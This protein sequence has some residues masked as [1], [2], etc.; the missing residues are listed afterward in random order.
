MIK[1]LVNWLKGLTYYRCQGYW[2]ES[3]TDH[4][5]E[6]DCNAENSGEFTC[7]HCLVNGGIYN[8]DTGKED[9]IRYFLINYKDIL[10]GLFPKI[11]FII[12]GKKDCWNC[13]HT[14]YIDLDENN[15]TLKCRRV[16]GLIKLVKH[17]GYCIHWRNKN[18]KN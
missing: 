2:S 8:P 18:D 6:F 10:K 13:K 3:N 7:E 1:R 14:S 12:R 5:A 15:F 16:C 9:Y 17:T 4:P 11:I